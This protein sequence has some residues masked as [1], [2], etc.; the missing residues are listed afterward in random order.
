MSIKNRRELHRMMDQMAIERQGLKNPYQQLVIE[1]KEEYGLSPI[2]AKALIKK[3]QEF[4]ESMTSN[5]R[6]KEQI[7]RTVVAIGEPAGRRL[8]NCKMVQVN[9]TMHFWG[10]DKIARAKGLKHLK[11]LKVHQLAMECYKQ[12]GLLTHEDLQDILGISSSTIKRIIK[13]YKEQG[14]VVPTRG[15]IEDIG[16]GITHKERIIEL[17]VRGYLYSEVMIQTSHTEASIE[18]YER[19]FVRIAYLHREGKNDLK[20][21]LITGYSEALIKSFKE[22]YEKNISKYPEAVNKMLERFQSYLE[23]DFEKKIG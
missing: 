14:I 13:S 5:E 18:N 23:D 11:S 17:L 16:P 4:I 21:R 2:E 20:I 6:N 15:Q 12:G 8:S 1:L 7:T 19:K 3:I 10:E 9:L 22:L